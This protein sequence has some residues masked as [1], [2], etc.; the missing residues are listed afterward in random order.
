MSLSSRRGKHRQPIEKV[1]QTSCLSIVAFLISV[2]IGC[3]DSPTPDVAQPKPKSP[4]VDPLTVLVGHWRSD[5]NDHHYYG[6]VDGDTNRGNFTMIR[7]TRPDKHFHHAYEPISNNENDFNVR[8]HFAYGGSEDRRY[9]VGKDGSTLATE[10]MA[11][12]SIG[13]IRVEYIRVDDDTEP[14]KK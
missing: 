2:C 3:A 13:R 9:E 4:P 14:A 6:P 5:S 7:G 1:E 8:I 11:S 10:R 12:S